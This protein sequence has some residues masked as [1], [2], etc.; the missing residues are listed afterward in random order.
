M[1]RALLVLGIS[2]SRCFCRAN[3][4]TAGVD[5]RGE[6]HRDTRG[7]SL[8]GRCA[9]RGGNS[10]VVADEVDVLT[11]RFNRDGS[12]NPIQLRGTCA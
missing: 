3:C 12:P 1:K 10:V 2:E 6:R 8:S 11:A 5:R 4:G 7:H 9:D